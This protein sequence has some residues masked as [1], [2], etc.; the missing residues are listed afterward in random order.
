M[1]SSI[2]IVL[3]GSVDSVDKAPSMKIRSL[4]YMSLYGE[5]GSVDNAL[6]NCVEKYYNQTCAELA[7]KTNDRII[8]PDA[9][10]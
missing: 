4:S 1:H 5:N 7:F 6:I 8:M 2:V 3:F 9:I 10:I